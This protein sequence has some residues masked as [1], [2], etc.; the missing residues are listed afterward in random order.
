[1]ILT[2]N[3]FSYT[4]GIVRKN[5]VLKDPFTKA[6]VILYNSGAGGTCF[7]SGT[8]LFAQPND[9][10][11]PTNET[12][13]V[14]SKES[15]Q[16]F[17]LD[18]AAGAGT[19]APLRPSFDLSTSTSSLNKLI[20]D[21]KTKAKILYNQQL[22]KAPTIP[23]TTTAAVDDIIFFDGDINW[24]YDVIL[25][26]SKD[27][28]LYTYVTSNG[29][30][31][32]S[33]ASDW[34]DLTD[35]PSSA[36][37][38]NYFSEGGSIFLSGLGTTAPP[39]N[40]SPL[41]PA[42]IQKS[43]SFELTFT[44][45]A[46]TVPAPA[47]TLPGP[48][49]ALFPANSV[50]V[51][52]CTS[53]NKAVSPTI[54]LWPN[55][56]PGPNLVMT[57]NY[58]STRLCTQ[59][60]LLNAAGCQCLPG[61]TGGS[62]YMLGTAGNPPNFL[63]V[64]SGTNGTI[65]AQTNWKDEWTKALTEK[66]GQTTADAMQ[67]YLPWPPRN[68]VITLLTGMLNFWPL[69]WPPA[70]IGFYQATPKR[71]KQAKTF[72][73][74]ENSGATATN[75]SQALN[76]VF[77]T[78]RKATPSNYQSINILHSSAGK[79]GTNASVTIFYQQNTDGGTLVSI[80]IIAIGSHSTDTSYTIDWVWAEYTTWYADQTTK[81]NAAIS[82]VQNPTSQQGKAQIKAIDTKYETIMG[83]EEI[84]KGTVYTL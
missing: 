3:N 13:I 19:P 12:Y 72:V 11:T 24:D 43:P 32:W 58:A 82:G 29:Y 14:T 7:A 37:I 73:Q 60:S 1:M 42:A 83:T 8:V 78:G 31:A 80:Q 18:A 21:F 5:P 65:Q 53:T 22:N 38:K 25:L 77:G 68:Q 2:Q 27:L 69:A 55:A 44:P 36:D 49:P 54:S 34:N 16:L 39:N 74:T 79:K 61:D 57:K 81:K 45:P 41:G 6:P 23:P 47:L 17:N 50:Q 62:V 48:P 56:T 30:A 40:Y 10:S 70:P 20:S 52:N 15:L 75:I 66:D 71:Q 63:G 33:D 67:P 59:G 46:T 26:K 35:M 9:P 28:G 4:Q 84:V 76:V 51:M 64:I